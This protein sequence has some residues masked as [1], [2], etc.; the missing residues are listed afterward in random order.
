MDKNRLNILQVVNSLHWHAIGNYALAL[1]KGLK[2]RGHKVIFI[3][4]PNSL[5]INRAEEA[6]LRVIT[7][8]KLNHYHPAYFL[9][10]V[11]R[12]MKL[13]NEEEIDVLN[14]HESY[15]FAISCLAAKLSRRPIALIRTRGTFMPPKGHPVNR[16]LHNSLTDKVIVT[17]EFMQRLCLKHLRGQSSH[18]LLIYGGVDIEQLKLCPPD[19]KL[20]QG[21]SIGED[22]LVIGIIG[23]FDPIKG[24]PYFFEAAS[25]ISSSQE[26]K[27]LVI[28]YESELSSQQILDLAESYGLKKKTIIIKEWV[29]L[30]QIL[31]IIDIGVVSSIGSEANSRSTLEF[32]AC[33]KPV[34]ATK[35]GVIPELIEPGESGF[36]VPP[37]QPEILAEKITELVRD[38]EKREVMGLLARRMVEERFSQQTMVDKTEE[39]YYRIVSQKQEGA[40]IA[41]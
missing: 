7:N 17:S 40:A 2:D 25:K 32:M 9:K 23:R 35:V 36:L 4:L 21:L 20:K 33:G 12:L 41:D 39:L 13:L 24:Y 11:K 15:G 27:L 3:T 30:P 38:K 10:D 5:L 31:S 28:G 19:L 8:L 18:Y 1:S 6:G 22:D 26:I 29:N 34:V 14:V 37:K 16:Y